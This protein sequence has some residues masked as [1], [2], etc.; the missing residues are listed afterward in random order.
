MV[1]TSLK[2]KEE[3]M[4]MSVKEERIHLIHNAIEDYWFVSPKI[5]PIDEPNIVF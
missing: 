1:A 5:E 4:A 2:V 3:L